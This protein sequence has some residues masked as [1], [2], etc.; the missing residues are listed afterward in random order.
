MEQTRLANAALP[1]QRGPVAPAHLGQ[2][3][4]PGPLRA[5]VNPE[6]SQPARAPHT[7][8]EVAQI[9]PSPRRTQRGRARSRHVAGQARVKQRGRHSA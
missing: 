3:R 2:A 1:G 5:L 9:L 4:T 8:A 7:Q 6:R